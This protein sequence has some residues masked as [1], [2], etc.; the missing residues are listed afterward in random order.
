MQPLT[1]MSMSGLIAFSPLRIPNSPNTLSS[2]FSRI[3]QVLM[4]TKSADFSSSTE[5]KPLSSNKPRMF[6]SSRTLAWQ[7]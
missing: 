5:A 1:A 2:A 3:A 4:I 6:S 7:P